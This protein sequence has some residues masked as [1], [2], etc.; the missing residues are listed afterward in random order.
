MEKDIKQLLTEKLN[1]LQEIYNIVNEQKVLI[2]KKE[3]DRYQMIEDKK[4]ELLTKIQ[5]I[6]K[7]LENYNI[8][9]KKNFNN[10][11]DLIKKTNL[12]LNK[13]I[14]FEKENAKKIEELNLLLLGNH[15]E[16]YKKIKK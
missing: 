1:C 16:F 9:N 10:I 8:I 6:E 2:E 4:Q 5:E 13:L 3:F 7:F 11:Q 15:I 14:H 12:L